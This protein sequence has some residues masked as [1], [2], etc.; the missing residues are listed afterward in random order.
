MK[1]NK[2]IQLL[3]QFIQ[4]KDISFDEEKQLLDWLSDPHS[5]K[6]LNALYQDTWNSSSSSE[7]S[8]DIQERMFQQ[9]KSH[10]TKEAVEEKFVPVSR[11]S[12]NWRRWLNYAA[13]LIVCLG[14]GLSSHLYTRSFFIRQITEKIYSVKAERGQRA[15]I[16][17][18]DGTKVWL[19]SHTEITYP[20]NYGINDRT[21]SLKG[22]AFFEV[23]KDDKSR[24]IVKTDGLSVEALGTS[25]NVKAYDEDNEITA[26]LFTGKVKA[27]AWGKEVILLPNQ[28]ASFYRDNHKLIAGNTEDSSYARMWLDNELSFKGQ[29]LSEIAVTLGRISNVHIEFTSEKIKQYKFSGVIKNNSLDNVIEI[30]SLTAPI[31]YESRG[32][33]IILSEKK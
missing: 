12:L 9:I 30:I 29:T 26:T 15:N 21:V 27:M 14:I 25:F 28:F 33:T 13:I 23:A 20:S 2:D 22:E 5:Q 3:E 32:D 11:H 4:G 8:S 17:L 24:F 6:E 18:P 7:L 1:S 19:N 10:I 31:M 16:T